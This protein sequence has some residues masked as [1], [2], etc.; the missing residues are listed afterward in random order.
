MRQAQMISKTKMLTSIITLSG[1]LLLGGC[2]TSMQAPQDKKTDTANLENLQ[3]LTNNST[4]S[5]ASVGK[6]RLDA[7][8]DT[9]LTLGAQGGL[10]AR[11]KQINQQTLQNSA[12][13]D[14]IFNF[15]RLIL[16]NNVLPPV[17]VE[18]SQSM[19]LDSSTAIRLS[20]QIYKIIQQAQ[21]VT[22]APNW[23]QYLLLDF[24]NPTVP[25]STLLPKNHT[26]RTLWNKYIQEGWQ[27]GIQQAN[28]IYR[29]NLARLQRDFKGMILYRKLLA[30]NIVS[31]PYVA[32]TNLG[33][34]SNKDHSQLYINDRVM[35]ITALPQLN[36]N[37]S[38][39]KPIVETNDGKKPASK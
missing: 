17:L 36:P 37:S 24:S 12:S 9:A 3:Q 38:S 30:E 4:P 2:A 26:E 29:D 31:S 23:R 1:A 8:K 32:K 15:N 18:A 21:F 13:L 28:N 10:A 25:D 33:V 16:D 14:Q 11:A 27:Q 39:W 35:R 20:G 34:T 7:I 22:T 19:N 5:G 6:I